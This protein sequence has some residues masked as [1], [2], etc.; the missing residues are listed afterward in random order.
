MAADQE[1]HYSQRNLSSPNTLPRKKNAIITNKDIVEGSN[2][3]QPA[4]GGGPSKLVFTFLSH[5]N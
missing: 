5:S 4:F 2:I 1:K 3:E